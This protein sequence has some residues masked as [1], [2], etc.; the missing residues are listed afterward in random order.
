MNRI[1]GWEQRLFKLTSNAGRRAFSW[2]DHDCVTFAA[3]CVMA[4][5]G[6]DPIHDIR[7]TWSTEIGAKRAMLK[8]GSRDLGDLAAA[9]LEEIPISQTKRGDIVLAGEENS[10]DFL[11]I[12]VGHMAAGP[13][14]TGLQHISMSQ[15]KRAYRV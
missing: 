13:A 8:A 15:A 11:A 4:M 5:T 2:G 6:Y 3:D 14:E 7:G 1:K 9:R 12:V 10:D